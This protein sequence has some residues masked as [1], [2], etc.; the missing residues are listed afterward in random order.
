MPDDRD[1]AAAAP[2]VPD[3]ADVTADGPAAAGT[4]APG[5]VP[6]EEELLRTAT[7]ARVRRAPRYRAFVV[8]GALLGLVVAVVLVAVLG[9]DRA[10]EGAGG[11]LLPVLDGVGGVRAVVGTGGAI[12]GALAG[13]VVALLADRRSRRAR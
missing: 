9:D 2:E 12:L 13:G 10:L 4:S 6:T 7:P 1:P 11:G 8:T 5:P 3:P